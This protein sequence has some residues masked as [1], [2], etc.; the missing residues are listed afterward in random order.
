M[1]G[2]A[3]PRPSNIPEDDTGAAAAFQHYVAWCKSE[4]QWYTSR[5]AWG[6][7]MGRRIKKRETKRGNVYAIEL[8]VLAEG[9]G[10]VNGSRPDPPPTV[11]PV[12]ATKQGV[13]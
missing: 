8:G 12:L 4:G 3:A 1:A 13:L 11:P 10:L 2:L 6:T 5:T 9:G 7:T